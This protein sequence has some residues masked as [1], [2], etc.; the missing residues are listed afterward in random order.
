MTFKV[1]GGIQIGANVA[2]DS[3]ALIQQ[4]ES[5][6]SVRPTLQFDFVR[7]R[8]VDSR[9]TFARSSNATCMGSDGLYHNLSS[10]T[11]RIEYNANGE[12]QGLLIEYS[13]TNLIP[14]SDQFFDTTYWTLANTYIAAS[15]ATMGPDG[16]GPVYKAIED[17][18]LGEHAIKSSNINFVANTQYT[19]TL[20]AKA[21]ERTKFDM[22]LGGGS[23][24]VNGS[25]TAGFDLSN[26][27]IFAAA[28]SPATA[29]IVSVG[30]GW[31][32]CTLTGTTN[33]TSTSAASCVVRLYDNTPS[34]AYTGDGGS[35]LYVWGPQLEAT[36]WPSSYIPASVTFTSRSSNG[37]YY[38]ANGLLM[39][40][41]TNTLRQSYNPNNAKADP[42]YLLEP[43]A[44]NLILYSE[45]FD[46][47]GTWYL[48]GVVPPVV[49]ANATTAPDGTS[50]ADLW[51]RSSTAY[52]HSAQWVTKAASPITYTFSAFV[53][54]SV[55]NYFP[56]RMQGLYPARADVRFNLATG[57]IDAGSLSVQTGFSNPSATINYISNGW[58][59][60]TLTATTD[61]VSQV[62][63]HFSFL[64]TQGVID[65]TDTASNSAGYIWG[66]QLEQGPSVTSYIQ[67]GAATATRAADVYSAASTTT[68][69]TDL[70]SM[71]APYY[72]LTPAQGT[73]F[74]D[75]NMDGDTAN[76]Q[77]IFALGNGSTLNLTSIKI[78]SGYMQG[79]VY[80]NNYQHNG[81]NNVVAIGNNKIAYAYSNTL[82]AAVVNGG[83]YNVGYADGYGVAPYNT[84]TIGSGYDY[85]R[86][87]YIRSVS[88]YPRPLTSS[89][90]ISITS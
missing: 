55:G 47:S 21:G 70:L 15:A 79:H 75:V 78:A 44:T 52:N 31:Y 68:R 67:T 88:Y 29:N 62:G 83:V 60:I 86:R 49:T 89:E 24:W 69:A 22:L 51:T 26:G 72:A 33:A 63:V 56:L 87:G 50:S 73:M 61:N 14:G 37:T 23:N 11:P 3:D 48:N 18:N 77:Y 40:A 7:G 34:G 20:F 58:Y 4:I 30:D 65:S 59:R 6:A 82:A 17:T 2:F 5:T 81:V 35:G 32:R 12:C 64:T 76:N 1:K 85:L 27:T 19:F 39:T 41:T 74:V 25:R 80:N 54:K 8:T 45:Q 66:A 16:N 9:L 71:P 53:K 90:M 46:V 10:N 28:P 36:S 84:L 42:K 38:A 43:A 13:S 57:T